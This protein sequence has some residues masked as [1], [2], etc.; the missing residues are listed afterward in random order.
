[1]PI[2]LT[3]SRKENINY[4]L[5]AFLIAIGISE[6]FSFLVWFE[7]I[8]PFGSATLANPTPIMGHISY[9]PF[10]AFAIYLVLHQLF[11]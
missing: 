7:I 6:F 1:L 11:F 10:L 2:F 5:Y 9:N 4:Y 3:I 8:E